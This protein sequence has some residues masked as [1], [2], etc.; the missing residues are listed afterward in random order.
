M[1][2]NF[3]NTV[4]LEAAVDNFDEAILAGEYSRAKEII[5]DMKESGFS[6]DAEQLEVEL[7]EAKVADLAIEVP[8]KI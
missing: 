6:D 4:W 7:L 1:D 2:E 8:V 5:A 3:Q